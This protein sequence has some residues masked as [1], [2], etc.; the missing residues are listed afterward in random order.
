MQHA[1]DGDRAV[2]GVED[3]LGAGEV[4]RDRREVRG[5]VLGR[6]AATGGVDEEVEQLGGAVRRPGEQEAATAET[7]Q[8]GF[9]DRGRKAGGD[10]GVHGVAAGAQDGQGG[11]HRLVVTGSDCCLE[12]SLPLPAT[13]PERSQPALPQVTRSDHRRVANPDGSSGGLRVPTQEG[14]RAPPC[15]APAC[16]RPDR[17]V[18]T[19]G[20]ATSQEGGDGQ[21]TAV[22]AHRGARGMGQRRPRA[23]ADAAHRHVADESVP[24]ALI[25]ALIWCAL[26]LAF[27]GM[28]TVLARRVEHIRASS[29]ATGAW[30]M[31]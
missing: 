8:A 30:R 3:L 9:G 23:G 28:L 16:R 13:V 5:E 24:V 27:A 15:G 2:P 19:D 4:D 12:P 14:S 22:G 11:L 1:G 7:G 20:D 6:Q 18:G 21:P 25:P 10:G 17:C 26:G 31:R 29:R